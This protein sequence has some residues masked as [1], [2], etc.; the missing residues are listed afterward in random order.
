[1]HVPSGGKFPLSSEST[2][3]PRVQVMQE[4][5]LLTDVA[6]EVHQAALLSESAEL[7][8]ATEANSYGS[9]SLYKL[10]NGPWCLG[11]EKWMHAQRALKGRIEL[12]F[13]RKQGNKFVYRGADTTHVILWTE[14]QVCC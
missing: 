13:L 10:G 3:C 5:C 1:M 9:S 14:G 8:R 12:Q 2:I 11:M 6:T 7:D 4:V